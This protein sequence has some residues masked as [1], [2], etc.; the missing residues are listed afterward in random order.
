EVSDSGTIV[1]SKGRP[2]AAAKLVVLASGPGQALPTQLGFRRRMI[3][4]AHSL[5]VGF[6]VTG[7]KVPAGGLVHRGERPGDRVGF[8]SVFPVEGGL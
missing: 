6:T 4:E 5:C 8:A 3:R 1:L 7:A 2:I